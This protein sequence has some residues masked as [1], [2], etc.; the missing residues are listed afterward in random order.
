MDVSACEGA[1][2]PRLDA[3]RATV[4][5]MERWADRQMVKWTGGWMDR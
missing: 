4:E 5:R 3:L 2:K 1:H